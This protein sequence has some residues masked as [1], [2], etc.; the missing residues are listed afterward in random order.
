MKEQQAREAERKKMVNAEKNLHDWFVEIKAN[1][2]KEDDAEFNE[3]L[4]IKVRV[5]KEKDQAKKIIQLLF[6]ESMALT[7]DQRID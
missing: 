2:E 4:K 5:C 1:L 7:N 6:H 3:L